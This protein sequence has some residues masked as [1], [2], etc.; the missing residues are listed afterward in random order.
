MRK[1]VQG[2]SFPNEDEW[3]L[4]VAAANLRGMGLSAF[5]RESCLVMA[6]LHLGRQRG[7]MLDG[8]VFV[9]SFKK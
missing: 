7:A 6:K 9:E 1:R 2:I 3:N 4:I 8:K 5:V